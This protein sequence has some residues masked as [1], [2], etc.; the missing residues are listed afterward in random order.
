MVNWRHTGP[1]NERALRSKFCKK[2]YHAGDSQRS[3]LARHLTIRAGWWPA[4]YLSIATRDRTVKR[5]AQRNRY[6]YCT[7][8]VK[9]TVPDCP[10]FK[11][12]VSVH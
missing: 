4:N 10:G 2:L 3:R 8:T 11:L 7:V 9:T 6:V 5:V 1:N 12:P